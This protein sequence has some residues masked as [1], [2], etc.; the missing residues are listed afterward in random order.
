VSVLVVADVL[1]PAPPTGPPI[2]ALFAPI[3][4]ALPRA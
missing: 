1:P 3:A 2:R 4:A